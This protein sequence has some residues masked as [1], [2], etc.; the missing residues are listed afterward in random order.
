MRQNMDRGLN[1]A[2]N[3]SA[4]VKMYPSFV[5]SLPDGT[6]I[7]IHSG[8]LSVLQ[9]IKPNAKINPILSLGRVTRPYCVLTS[10]D[11]ELNSS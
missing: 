4:I 8:L 7:Y 5:R 11:T 9:L 2:T 6:G 10:M 1:S 3:A